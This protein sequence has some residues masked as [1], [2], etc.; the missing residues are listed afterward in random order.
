MQMPQ[1]PYDDIADIEEMSE[2][3]EDYVLKIFKD[4]SNSVAISALMTASI[5]CIIGRCPNLP[6]LLAH[7]HSFTHLLNLTSLDMV[8]RNLKNP[9]NS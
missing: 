3:I 7:I 6:E 8:S 9:P 5:N 2:K 1:I 4:A